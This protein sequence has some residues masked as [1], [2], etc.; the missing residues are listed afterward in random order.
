[1][2]LSD[3][4]AGFLAAERTV[5]QLLDDDVVQAQAI[6][7]T[8]YFAGWSAIE[9]LIPAPVDV[10]PPTAAPVDHLAAVIYPGGRAPKR[11]IDTPGEPIAP[12]MLADIDASTELT[13]GEWA[14]IR[15][16]F[17]LYCER[18]QALVLESGRVLG[19]DVFGRQSSE[20]GPDITQAENELRRG[21]FFQPVITI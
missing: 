4:V 1:M 15:P 21:A 16:L 7:A 19:V 3:L 14:L 17:L 5:G 20:I 13:A 2:K 18:E 8:R 9:S 12:A 10:A 6:A 11:Y